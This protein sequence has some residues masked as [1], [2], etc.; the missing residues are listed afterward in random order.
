MYMCMYVYVY[1]CSRTRNTSSSRYGFGIVKFR[2]LVC[3]C[4]KH[5]KKNVIFYVLYTY[6]HIDIRRYVRTY[7][8]YDKKVIFTTTV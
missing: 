3:I 5:E 2:S 1:T 7:I 6:I 4:S 8:I